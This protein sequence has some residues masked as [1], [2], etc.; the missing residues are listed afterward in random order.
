M[1]EKQENLQNFPLRSGEVV[2]ALVAVKL[3][4]RRSERE[5]EIVSSGIS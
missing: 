1:W 5:R 2:R 4:V 3:S